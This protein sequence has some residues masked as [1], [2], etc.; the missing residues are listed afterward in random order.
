[1]ELRCLTADQD[2]DALQPEWNALVESSL[3]NIPFMRYE[4]LRAW[5]RTLGGGE[6]AKAS[7]RIVEAR[8]GGALTGLAPFFRARHEE[9]TAWLLLGSFEV[10]DYLDVVAARDHESDFARRLLEFAEAQPR[11]EFEVLDLYN[12]RANSPALEAL[13]QSAPLAAW[14]VE[15]LQISSCPNITLPSSWE[16]YLEQ[17]DRRQRH[18]VR[19]KLRRAE[20]G[21]E[22][23]AWS[24]VGPEAD[25][26]AETENIL[27]LMRLDERKAKFLTPAMAVQFRASLAAAHAAGWLQLAFLTVDGSPAAAY[28]NLDYANRI[29]VYNSA[30]DPRF[31]ALS[32]GW[33]LL[34]RLIEW[35]IDHGREALDF[36]RGSEGYK[37]Q[38]GGVSQ[39]IYRLR[40]A[41]PA[42]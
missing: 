40:L 20:G 42:H 14:H 36:M 33:I 37:F 25:L 22:D 17:L 10:T 38:W 16:A 1:M 29:W 21:E 31:A 41:R 2:F 23:V 24:I 5:W 30:I 26:Q 11:G 6:W 9:R 19:R 7:L 35:A 18:E 12:L 3:A 13:V 34:A 8:E 27:A 39:P 32:P 15:K 4:Y 28:F